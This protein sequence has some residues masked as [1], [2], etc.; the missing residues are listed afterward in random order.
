MQCQPQTAVEKSGG[1]NFQYEMIT[2][3]W[4]THQY[5]NGLLISRSFRLYEVYLSIIS[6]PMVHNPELT[7]HL[8][9][10]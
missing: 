7:A 4:F 1:T 6:S 2:I 5:L 10:S 8:L 9:V 3:W